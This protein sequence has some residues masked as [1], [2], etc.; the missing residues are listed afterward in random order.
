MRQPRASCARADDLAAATRTAVTCSEYEGVSR[1]VR[2]SKL[3]GM[4]DDRKNTAINS[5]KYN[6]DD[7]KRCDDE[8]VRGKTRYRAQQAQ[9]TASR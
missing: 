7:E 2:V 4:R 5:K 6:E 3:G 8:R 9:R 1:R